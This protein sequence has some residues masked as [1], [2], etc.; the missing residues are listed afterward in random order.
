MRKFIK[1]ITRWKY[2][3]PAWLF[4]VILV[5]ISLDIMRI[6]QLFW[7]LL[8]MIIGSLLLAA[9]KWWGCL[10]GS[11]FG[12]Y[13]IAEYYSKIRNH[14]LIH[15]GTRYIGLIV[16][17][18]YFLMAYMVHKSRKNSAADKQYNNTTDISKA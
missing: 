1:I 7:L 15:L 11:I 16:I 8:P 2:S 17:V 18:Y 6:P 3:F 12:A 4:T 5:F 13:C 14:E 9:E 10:V